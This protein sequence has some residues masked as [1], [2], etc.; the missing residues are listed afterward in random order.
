MGIVEPFEFLIFT[1]CIYASSGGKAPPVIRFELR[2]WCENSAFSAQPICVSAYV[3]E[4]KKKFGIWILRRRV[5][6]ICAKRMF[7]Y[8]GQNTE[9]RIQ[10]AEGGEVWI[11][12]RH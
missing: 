12:A 3:N 4:S 1:F 11:F 5:L 2:V 10:E 7:E 9:C 6:R 8:E